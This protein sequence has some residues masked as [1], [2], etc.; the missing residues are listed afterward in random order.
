MYEPSYI[1]DQDNNH[2]Y[3]SGCIQVGQDSI[4]FKFVIHLFPSSIEDQCP[5]PVQYTQLLV[6]GYEAEYTRINGE[7]SILELQEDGIL[8]ILNAIQGR[9]QNGLWNVKYRVNKQKGPKE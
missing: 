2:W 4:N 8:R 1:F 6:N 3:T 5:G 7:K 9:V